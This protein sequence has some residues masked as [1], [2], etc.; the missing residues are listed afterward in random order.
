MTNEEKMMLWLIKQAPNTN[1]KAVIL[2]S[3]I[4]ECGP[5]SEEAGTKVRE[6]LRQKS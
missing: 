5:L 6:L 1:T 3:F 2:Q 4:A